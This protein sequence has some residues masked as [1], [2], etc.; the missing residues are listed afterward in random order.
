MSDNRPYPK[1]YKLVLNSVNARYID[2]EFIFD[3][4]LPTFDSLNT[5]MGWMLGVE[6]FFTS[7]TL[8]GITLTGGGAFG[9]LHLRELSQI[10]SYSSARKTCTDVILTFNSA[11]VINSFV[12]SSVAQP[13]TDEQ[14]WVN[15]QLTFYFSNSSLAKTA[16]A[17]NASF[18]IVLSLWVNK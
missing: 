13:I 7:T 3:V 12:S 11:N 17:S 16:V 8:A 1:C 6:S 5:K 9:N 4:N 18:Q 10:N 14:F 15:K 2:N